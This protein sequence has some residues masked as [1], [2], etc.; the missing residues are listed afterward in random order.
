MP[1]HLERPVTILRDAGSPLWFPFLARTP[2]GG[3][4]L[5]LQHGW[6]SHF[7]PQYQYR[8][9]DGGRSWQGPTQSVPRLAWGHSF[10]DGERLD[11]DTYGVPV[12]GRPGEALLLA[13]WSRPDQPNAPV[14]RGFARCQVPGLGE[15]PLTGLG[16]YPSFPWRNLWQEAGRTEEFRRD[17]FVTLGPC[18]TGGMEL[19]DGRLAV[20][21]YWQKHGAPPNHWGAVVM[22]STDRG[23]HWQQVGTLS[24]NLGDP[25]PSEVAMTRLADGRWYVV[26]R[27]EH[28][29]CP[30]LHHAW[31]EDQ[32]RTWTPL[33]PLCLAAGGPAAG[34][35]WP[36][37]RVLANGWLALTCGR[38]G[39][40]LYFD[41]SGTGT[42][43]QHHVDLHAWEL[44]TQA[45]L[46]VSPELRLRG[47]VGRPY[48]Q[49]I[50]RQTDSGDYLDCVEVAPGE[51]LVVYDVQ[52]YV[53]HWN[54]AP[55]VSAVRMVSIK[56]TP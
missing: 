45:V 42:Q 11:L 12:A 30:N 50:D 13:V 44:D 43:W 6:D 18:V 14:E 55:V 1:I 23:R 36:G 47:V 32:G 2:Q 26:A 3:L 34:H 15:L 29:P 54:A 9:A 25:Q 27:M 37:L 56:V 7:A 28:P 53:E 40:Q 38:P 16:G 22:I 49:P 31:S 48:G 51:L 39:K 5:S 35:V 24:P 17:E 8:S 52:G 4:Q 10:A 46:G 41:P 33:R 20:V 19:P 21:G